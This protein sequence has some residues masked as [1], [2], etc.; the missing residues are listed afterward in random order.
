MER[1]QYGR[2]FSLDAERENGAQGWNRTS[3]TV[4]F[5]HVTA[6]IPGNPRTPL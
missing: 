3:D 1:R 4:I 2:K 6:N 5:S